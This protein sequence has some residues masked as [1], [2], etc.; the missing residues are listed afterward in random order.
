M[1]KIIETYMKNTGKRNRKY[2]KCL[3]SCGN[4]C[5]IRFDSIGK[6]NSCGCLKKEQDKINLIKNHKH[7]LSHSKLWNTYYGMKKRCYDKNDKR[8]DDYG[9]RGIKV[10]DEWLSSFEN[11][12]NWAINNGFEN[13][14]DIS[15]DR[16]DNNSNYS[17]KNCRWANAKTQSR[18]RRSNLKIFFEGKYTT[19]MELSE[20][21]NL[22]YKLVYDRIKRGDSIKE[23]IS[24]EKLPMGV[25]CRG[26]KNHKAV[27]TEKQVLEIRKLR[28]EGFSL[29]YIKNKYNISKSAVS[30]IVNRRTWKHI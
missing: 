18:N 3:C 26:E 4:I 8:Y 28:L 21:V 13:S 16:I 7:R 30:A 24:K 14:K 6:T 25:K 20:K 17:P 12:V 5:E 23:I 27:L 1:L 15:L 29:D 19:A 2:A 11:F 22:P 10:C 9:G